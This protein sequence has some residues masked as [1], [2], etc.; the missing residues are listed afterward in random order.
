MLSDAL[1]LAPGLPQH[2]LARGNGRNPVQTGLCIRAGYPL[3]LKQKPASPSITN[4]GSVVRTR[5]AD[6]ARVQ[7]RQ[8]YQDVGDCRGVADLDAGADVGL[9]L[10]D[11]FESVTSGE[12]RVD[13]GDADGSGGVER[14]Q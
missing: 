9:L 10:P 11:P 14:R 6:A 3:I 5:A 12:P 4:V 2:H 8:P 13:E 7:V 1:C